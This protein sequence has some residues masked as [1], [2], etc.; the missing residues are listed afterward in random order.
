MKNFAI[1]CCGLGLAMGAN[2]SLVQS[3][4]FDFSSSFLTT[5]PGTLTGSLNLFDPSLGDLVSARLTVTGNLRGFIEFRYLGVDVGTLSPSGAVDVGLGFN[6]SLGAIDALFNGLNDLPMSYGFSTTLN[7]FETDR[8]SGAGDSD[9]LVFSSLID[10]AALQGVGTFSMSCD[11]TKSFAV[12]GA[13]TSNSITSTE[14]T[15]SWCGA[16]IVY[17]YTERG[18]TVPVPGSMALAGLALAGLGLAR[19]RRAAK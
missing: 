1:L 15:D 19:R 6:S 4:S 14:R 7:Q 18:N 2:A 8:S 17:H 9:S 10:L 12:T 3:S 11:F 5:Q 16:E 13:G